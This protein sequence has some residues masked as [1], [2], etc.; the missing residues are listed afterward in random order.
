MSLHSPKNQLLFLASREASGYFALPN[1]YLRIADKGDW[2]NL[3]L[4]TFTTATMPMPFKE[5][6]FVMMPMVPVSSLQVTR[7]ISCLD[8]N[9][10]IKKNDSGSF[11]A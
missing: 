4:G 3:V 8:T 11:R 6:T 9:V 10:C 7:P 1:I 5:H 2:P